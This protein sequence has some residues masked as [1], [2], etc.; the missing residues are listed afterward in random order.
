LLKRLVERSTNCRPRRVS[1][2]WQLVSSRAKGVVRSV[3]ALLI[4][5]YAR[6][7]EDGQALTEAF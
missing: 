2:E 5:L 6:S 4:A 3:P 7:E 1:L